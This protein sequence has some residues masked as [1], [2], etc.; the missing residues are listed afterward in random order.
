MSVPLNSEPQ[1]DDVLE[2]NEYLLM[3][4]R[5]GVPIGLEYSG[6]R[7]RLADRIKEINSNIAMGVARGRTVRQFLES[8]HELPPQYRVSL[9]TWL[10]CDKSPDALSVLSECAREHCEIERVINFA[11]VQPLILLGL[12]YLGCLYL[13]FGVMPKLDAIY[14]QIGSKPGMAMQFLIVAKRY[15]WV[16]GIA[17]PVVVGIGLTIWNLRSAGIRFRWFPGRKRVSEAIQKANCASSLGHLLAH[18]FSTERAVSAVGSFTCNTRDATHA[19]MPPLLSWALGDEVNSANRA[20][21]LQFSARAY[22]EL[23]RS[24]SSKLWAWFPAVVGALV[25]GVLVFVFGLS[26]FVP[27]IEL[28]TTLIRP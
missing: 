11:L 27:M 15:V 26:L 16:W 9:S 13:L 5:A 22:R 6:G 8:D 10:Y 4:D 25:G 1:L 7:E 21:A 3:L 19:A 2:F 23:A 18:D 20:D 12:V 17:V 14:M 24:G 28:L